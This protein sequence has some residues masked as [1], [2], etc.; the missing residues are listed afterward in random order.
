MPNI[1]NRFV[2][3]PPLTPDPRTRSAVSASRAVAFLAG[4]SASFI[5]GQSLHVDGCW[6]LH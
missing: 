6:L 1:H 5:A 2:G 4:P 3:P